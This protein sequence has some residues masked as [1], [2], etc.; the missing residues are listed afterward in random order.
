MGRILLKMEGIVKRYPGVVALKGVNFELK[1]GEVHALLGENGAGKSTL[2][3]I[4]SG[5]VLPDDGKIYLD[6]RQVSID[7]PR[8]AQTLGIGTVHQELSL[9]PSLSIAENIFLGRLPRHK[10]GLVDWQQIGERAGDILESLGLHGVNPWW[11]VHRL[12]IAE[13]QL[14]EIAR[15][16]T[17]D[18]KILVLDEPT[19]ALSDREVRRLFD[20]IQRLNARGVGIIYVSHRL[21]EVRQIA[22]RVTVLRDGRCVTTTRMEQIH[23]TDLVRLMVG[24]DVRSRFPQEKPPAKTSQP[25]LQVEG[26]TAPSGVKDV[27]LRVGRGEVVGLFGLIGAGRTEL[28][29]AIFGLDPIEKGRVFVDGQPVIIR[30]PHDAIRAGIGFVTEDRRQG[31]VY[32]LSVAQNV[33]LASLRQ[34]SPW[35]ILRKV[36]EFAVAD[37][38]VQRLH[39]HP[40]ALNR[41]VRFFS[42]GNQQKVILAKWLCTGARILILDEPTRGID[43]GA[44]TEVYHIVRQLTSEGKGILLISSDPSE[45]L[46]VSDRIAVMYRGRILS[47]VPAEQATEEILMSHAS[48][49]EVPA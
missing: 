2:M 43:V 31:L 32:P 46:G 13:Q 48:G 5:T 26:L 36:E 8:R 14:V 21:A 42:G 18:P 37:E 40:P 1:Q 25:L 12:R 20:I 49:L 29:R 22:H 45:V 15:V 17:W 7:S 33:T 39:V 19:S 30:S 44:K 16:L 6:N 38:F 41:P 11:P 27:H 28:A 34:L 24:R 23:D 10:S 35:G 3:K 4:V 9:V 47:E